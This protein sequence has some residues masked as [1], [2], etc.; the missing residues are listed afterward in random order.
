[1]DHPGFHRTWAAGVVVAIVVVACSGATPHEESLRE[2]VEFESVAF[3]GRLWDPFLPPLDTGRIVTI[4]GEL[5][6]PAGDGP[7]P[8]VVIEHGCGGP[9]NERDWMPVLAEHGIATLALDSF[10]G[11]GVVEVC[12]GRETV[13]VADLVVDVYRAAEVLRDDERIDGDRIAVMG[14]SFGGRT[15]L[16]S[17]LARFLDAYEG[18][19]FAAYLAFYPSTCFIRLDD[20]SDVAGGPIRIFHGT[21][22]DYTPIGP[23]DDFIGRL[24]SAGVDAGIHRYEGA[25]HA[26]DDRSLAWGV[27]HR[28]LSLP[29]PR[30]CTFVERDGKIVDALTG[31]VAGVGSA[32]IEFGVS[33][34]YDADARDAAERDLVAELTDVFGL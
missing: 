11:R 6:V 26:F 18:E 4:G 19:P 20:E 34:G 8:A 15:A 31:S 17:A 32:C 25:H 12:S 5:T 7:V 2:P 28:V 13:N 16:W 22:D 10:D 14:F 3:P 27:L 21:A 9:S 33:A 29:S 23:C 24:R 1:M 30:G